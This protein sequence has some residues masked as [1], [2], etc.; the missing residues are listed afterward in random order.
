MKVTN[1]VK[2]DIKV[3][4]WIRLAKIVGLALTGLLVVAILAFSSENQPDNNT[5]GNINVSW[6]T[7]L[8]LDLVKNVKGTGQISDEV[9]QLATATAIKYRQLPSVILSQYAYESMWGKSQSGQQDNN[10]F[11]ITWFQGSKYPKGTA[12]GVGGS[13]GGNYMKFPNAEE[14]F[15]YYGYMIASQDNFNKAVDNKNPG[16]VL[17]ILGKGGYASAGITESSPYYT[18]AMGIIKSN[19][20]TKYD[21][22]AIKNWDKSKAI[23]LGKITSGKIKLKGGGTLASSWDFPSEYKSKLKDPPSSAS[24]TTQPGNSYPV[25]QCTWYA[26]NREVE[27]G[28]FKDLSG[29]FGFLG[30]GQDWVRSLASKGWKV[31]STPTKGAVISTLGGAD[32][33]LA[34]YGHVSIVEYVNPDGSFLMSECN[35]NYV[36]D[37]VHYRV[38]NPAPYYTFATPK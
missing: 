34:M 11:G 9:A 24:M 23:S 28:N 30:N 27:L 14:C 16:E 18:G 2:A 3:Q 20:F 22:F 31:S 6:T 36:Q 29:T 35:Y 7:D 26:Y 38:A 10:Y 32:G 5:D 19:D 33:T 37:K 8:P 4:F 12:R 25:G 17:L 1:L 21:D 15:N 13:E